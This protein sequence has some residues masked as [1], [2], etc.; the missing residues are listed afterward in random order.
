MAASTFFSWVDSRSRVVDGPASDL[1]GRSGEEKKSQSPTA[2]RGARCPGLSARRDRHG[3]T[4]FIGKFLFF[5]WA[6]NDDNNN[7]GK[8]TRSVGRRGWHGDTGPGTATGTST[9]TGRP[10]PVRVIRHRVMTLL[11]RSL[12]S[13][14]SREPI[15]PRRTRLGRVSLVWPE[16][17]A[18]TSLDTVLST[19]DNKSIYSLGLSENLTKYRTPIS[20]L[21][22]SSLSS[23]S[24]SDGRN[25]SSP[26]AL[27]LFRRCEHYRSTIS[28]LP[29]PRPTRSPRRHSVIRDGSRPRC[30]IGEST[31]SLARGSSLIGSEGISHR[32]LAARLPLFHQLRGCFLS[33]Y[34][35]RSAHPYG[36]S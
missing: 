30:S 3:K 36:E 10:G 18:G 4:Q 8:N 17:S 5:G 6:V 27:A 22:V 13:D 2:P 26:Q 28:N 7:S 25:R 32:R 31:R 20:T 9:T 24:S 21:V 34:V 14:R 11:R 29:P 15:L 33:A 16:K 35:Y 1:S 12:P 19:I 23:P